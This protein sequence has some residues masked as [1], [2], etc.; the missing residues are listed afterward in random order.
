MNRT[1]KIT[2]AFVLTFIT[3]TALTL[4]LVTSKASDSNSN[5]DSTLTLVDFHNGNGGIGGSNHVKP[6][7]SI[8][9]DSG[10]GGGV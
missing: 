7:G 8:E 6:H 5:N 4:V 3:L 2:A 10:K 1:T 9:V